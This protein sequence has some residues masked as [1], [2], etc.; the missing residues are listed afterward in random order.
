MELLHIIV[1]SV[2]QGITEF[3][4]ISSWA[5]LIMIPKLTGWP[6]HGIQI[7][8]AVHVGTLLAVALYLWRDVAQMLRG[9]FLLFVGRW[10]PGARLLFLLIAATIPVVAAA[11]LFREHINAARHNLALIGWA[12]LVFGILLY[13]GDKRFMTL[14]KMEHV[15]FTHALALGLAQAVALL[16]PGASRSGVTMTAARFL[17][18]EREDAARLSL[19][20]SIPVGIGQAVLIG[21][22]IYQSGDL[23]LRTDALLAL[24]LAFAC[25]LLAIAGMMAWLRR[26]GFTPFVIYRIVV[27][28]GLL[29]WAYA[30]G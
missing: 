23:A 30:I 15:G 29:Y 17:A 8:A 26:A 13:V 6:D 7:E 11:L 14:R 3:L 16:I 19:L 18:F 25:A 22:E 4:P 2:M 27:G 10:T 12:M 28:V 5:H 24:G 20:L 21:R 9:L 1:V